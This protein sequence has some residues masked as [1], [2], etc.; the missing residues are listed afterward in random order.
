MSVLTYVDQSCPASQLWP[1][2]WVLCNCKCNLYFGY[3]RATCEQYEL[4][5]HGV[6]CKLLRPRQQ[7]LLKH[8]LVSTPNVGLLAYQTCWTKCG[9]HNW[10][11]LHTITSSGCR[12]LLGSAPGSALRRQLV[13]FGG[14]SDHSST[15]L[16]IEQRV[17][18]PACVH[19]KSKQEHPCSAC[20]RNRM[21]YYV[22]AGTTVA[23]ISV[24]TRWP[25]QFFLREAFGTV[26][27]QGEGWYQIKM[28]SSVNHF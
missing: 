23:A 13:R 26:L 1:W 8:A 20:T 17:R 9:K 19:N 15:V 12:I 11:R 14:N 25:Y 22:P 6:I 27:L 28:P 10:M 5:D 7:M 18:K 24:P 16:R 3:K 21:A 2:W 4:A